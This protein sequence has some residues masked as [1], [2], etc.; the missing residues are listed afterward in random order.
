MTQTLERRLDSLGFQAV[1]ASDAPVPPMFLAAVRERD[2]ARQTFRVTIGASAAACFLL[3][4][5]VTYILIP[6]PRTSTTNVAGVSTGSPPA[7]AHAAD[8]PSHPSVGNL[9]A[10]LAADPSAPLP[11]S[12]SSGV[13]PDKVARVGDGVDS[14]VAKDLKNS[15]PPP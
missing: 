9:T 13:D 7:P 5:L 12:P 6:T 11:S 14:P 8:A 3:A 4:G 10:Q 1:A 2:S 15:P